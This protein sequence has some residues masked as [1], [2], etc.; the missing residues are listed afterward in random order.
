VQGKTN[1][2]GENVYTLQIDIG[3]DTDESIN[4]GFI[5]VA[6]SPSNLIP[7]ALS[8][9]TKSPTHSARASL[10]GFAG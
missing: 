4:V 8:S 10:D 9:S 3:F 2:G 5:Q 6:P 7:L 1:D